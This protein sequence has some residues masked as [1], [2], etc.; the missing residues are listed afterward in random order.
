MAT[1]HED[2]MPTCTPAWWTTQELATWKSTEYINDDFRW[3]LFI[4][5]FVLPSGDRLRVV[6]APFEEA[7]FALDH[8]YRAKIALPSSIAHSVPRRQAEFF[9]GRLA[10]RIELH[11]HGIQHANIPI[12]SSRE[13]IWPVNF[14]GSISHTSSL[15]VAIAA[16]SKQHLGLGIDVERVPSS[17]S[18]SALCR[19]ALDV[20][21]CAYLHS[22]VGVFSLGELVTMAFS[23]KECFYK[24]AFSAVRR[25]LDFSVVRLS[26]I[27]CQRNTISLTVTEDLHPLFPLGHT[28]TV[29]YQRL[30]GQVFIS[31]FEARPSDEQSN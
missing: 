4:R 22:K 12:G 5:T 6:L 29:L 1:D 26:A 9:F 21:E 30:W 15:A 18:L 14:S 17:D 19:I 24:A 8:F 28:C 16:P 3:S 13:P 11:E 25:F 7:N 27:D 23:A 2:L 10:A 31:M 20:H